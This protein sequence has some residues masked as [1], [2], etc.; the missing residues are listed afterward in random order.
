M[1]PD[2][3]ERFRTIL[4]QPQGMVLVT[5][6]T[7]SGKT[8][9]LYSALTELNSVESKII[10][11]EDPVEYRL[12][13]INQVQVNEKID[14]IF[15][16]VLR[17]ALRQDPDIILVGEMRDQETAQIGHARRHDRPHG[18]LHPAHQRCRQ[19]ADSPARH[20]RAALHGGD[21]AAGGAGAAPGAPGMRKLR[22][23]RMRSLPTSMNG[24]DLE[25]GD[26]GR[27]STITCMAAAAATATAPA[28]RGAS[29]CTKCWRWTAP[30]SKRPTTATPTH[31]MK[32]ARQQMAGKTLRTQAVGEVI[33]GRTT[34]GEAM[35]ISNQLE[36]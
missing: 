17:S 27:N 25:L 10:T 34:V 23:N 22:R 6:P 5:G 8:T 30:W 14:L 11:V 16:R 35:R 13:G 33:N 32:M 12:P 9:T 21:V 31:F 15:R 7:G 3:L 1:P 29:V 19:H 36:D 26:A 2:M 20:G 4:R 18:A 24:C 28:T